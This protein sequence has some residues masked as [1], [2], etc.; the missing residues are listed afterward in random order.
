MPASNI[1]REKTAMTPGFPRH[2]EAAGKTDNALLL[3]PLA[4]GN[5]GFRAV[6]AGNLKRF[7]GPGLWP[8][9][10]HHLENDKIQ[11]ARFCNATCTIDAGFAVA[12]LEVQASPQ[13]RRSAG[14]ACGSRQCPVPQAPYAPAPNRARFRRALT[15]SESTSSHCAAARDPEGAF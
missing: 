9:C 8:H 2:T 5:P 4:I 11:T 1:T 7:V 3:D 12:G 13:P 6:N 14:R 10:F 15:A